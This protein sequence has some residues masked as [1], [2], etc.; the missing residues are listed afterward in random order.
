[1]SL[2]ENAAVTRSSNTT[3][4]RYK[5]WNMSFPHPFPHHP[6]EGISPHTVELTIW[7]GEPLQHIPKWTIDAN[8]IG[9]H[10]KLVSGEGLQPTYED[11]F[12][13]AAKEK[14][15]TQE[16]VLGQTLPLLCQHAQIH[17]SYASNNKQE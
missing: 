13:R 1:M 4:T 11:V 12:I 3:N 14:S 5:S 15:P 16:E 8:T 9:L 7:K 2:R 17:S 10:C 6:Q